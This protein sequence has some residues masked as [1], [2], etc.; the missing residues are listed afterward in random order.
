MITQRVT[1]LL[2]DEV[3]FCP[4]MVSQSYSWAMPKST[5]TELS[6]IKNDV[7]KVHLHTFSTLSD[8]QLL[9]DKREWFH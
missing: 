9:S 7:T 3:A 4:L 2:C 1:L 6:V 5:L 8:Q